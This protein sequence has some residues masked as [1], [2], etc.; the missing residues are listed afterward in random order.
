[1]ICHHILLC[2]FFHNLP[3]YLPH[4]FFLLILPCYPTLHTYITYDSNWLPYTTFNIL[5]VTQVYI[6]NNM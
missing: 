5:Y 1:M 6:L 2:T 3:K 4:V